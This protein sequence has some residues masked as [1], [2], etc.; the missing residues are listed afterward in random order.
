[1]AC[2]RAARPTNLLPSAPFPLPRRQATRPQ[3]HRALILRKHAKLAHALR[4][5]MLPHL[6][7]VG[8]EHHWQLL[9]VCLDGGLRVA[10]GQMRAELTRSSLQDGGNRDI[11]V[12]L[13]KLPVKI[14]NHPRQE[15][16]LLRLS[17]AKEVGSVPQQRGTLR[18]K[19]KLTPERRRY[20]PRASGSRSPWT[21]GARCRRRGRR[22]RCRPAPRRAPAGCA[23]RG[24]RGAGVSRRS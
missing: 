18:S 4:S 17:A 5:P 11:P 23:S 7:N 21:G 6:P 22:F 19:L 8:P 24:R 14:D 12:E 9:V 20:R 2:W 15:N 16:T 1:M 3:R 13:A 10:C